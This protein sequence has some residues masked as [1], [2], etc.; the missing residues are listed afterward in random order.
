MLR[1]EFMRHHRG[2]SARRRGRNRT[3]C[4]S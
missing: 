1:P 2:I 3:A 4:C